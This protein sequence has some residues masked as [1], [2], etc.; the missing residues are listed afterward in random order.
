VSECL[1]ATWS[2]L[3][4]SIQLAAGL[5]AAIFSFDQIRQGVL[6]AERDRL[7]IA[8]GLLANP[9]LQQLPNLSDWDKRMFTI[10][11]A[12]SEIVTETRPYDLA[13][14]WAALICG[15]LGTVWLAGSAWFASD[16]PSA[17]V[18]IGTIVML[19]LPIGGSL[20]INI[21]SSIRIRRNV[22]LPR[23]SLLNE[24][25]S[26]RLPPLSPTSLG[27]QDSQAKSDN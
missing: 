1:E 25:R 7:E 11:K 14:Q 18:S 2:S 21:H 22:S 15:V 8:D 20:W 27:R 17:V 3:Q 4:S 10:S 5:N 12:F 26:T 24:I 13:I 19:Y 16:C 9:R 23:V 6:S